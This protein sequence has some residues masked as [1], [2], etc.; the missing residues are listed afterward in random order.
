MIVTK[1]TKKNMALI[2]MNKGGCH[3]EVFKEQEIWKGIKGYEGLYEISSLGRVKSL[4]GWN[5]HAYIQREKIMKITLSKDN[6]H[7][8][9]V[10]LHKDKY[11][12]VHM[13]H[14]LV[15]ENFIPN[16]NNFPHVMHLDEDRHNNTL[17]NL[18]WGTAKENT[19]APLHKAR[20]SAAMATKR[21]KLNNFYGRT[22]T[23]ETKAKISQS[24]KGVPIAPKKVECDGKV[25]DSIAECARFYNMGKSTI[26]RYLLNFDL[27]P[28]YFKEKGLKFY[29]K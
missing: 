20:L 1:Q 8:D 14:R 11:S 10:T 15:A 21:G 19:N 13:V 6:K 25:F 5:G 2:T 9:V 12:K 3:M 28:I 22:H 27:M 17:S 4:V 24:R 29:D 18:K 23:S 26:R 7:Y 16:P